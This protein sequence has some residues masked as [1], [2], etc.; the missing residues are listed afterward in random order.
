MNNLIK[1]YINKLKK[2]NIEEFFKNN[3]IQ[4]TKNEIDI[5]YNLAKT[6]YQDI[7]NGDETEIYNLKK[8]IPEEKYNKLYELYLIYKKRYLK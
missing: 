3:N 5:L 6:K 4:L 8:Y 1:I 7:L 2:E